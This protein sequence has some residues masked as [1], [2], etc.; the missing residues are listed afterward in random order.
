MLSVQDMV[1]PRECLRRCISLATMCFDDETRKQKLWPLALRYLEEAK[2]KLQHCK[3]AFFE[4]CSDFE[5]KVLTADIPLPLQILEGDLVGGAVVDAK[6]KNSQQSQ[7]QTD[8]TSSS[9]SASAPS[10]P[11]SATSNPLE[12]IHAVT[13][14]TANA[15]NMWKD[16]Y[17]TL[18]ESTSANRSRVDDL[19]QML[20]F[21]QESYEQKTAQQQ[22][23]IEELK[24]QLLQA[25]HMQHIY[26]ESA[27]HLELMH[28]KLRERLKT[29]Q[30]SH[31]KTMAEFVC[32]QE[33]YEK[34]K[35]EHEEEKHEWQFVCQRMQKNT[36]GLQKQVDC[37]QRLFVDTIALLTGEQQAALRNV[38]NQL[39][40]PHNELTLEHA[41][42]RVENP[43]VNS[44]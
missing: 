18:R 40:N 15:R 7:Q 10:A 4:Q 43:H 20:A 27:V 5:R 31:E 9:A 24:R 12:A 23:T 35:R 6:H 3:D 41:V 33:E 1:A 29:V 34:Q 17:F 32:R 38:V 16:K 21:L 2:E 14:A 22:Q 8:S 28:A 11:S 26:E 19:E 36:D 13:I 30:Q 37:Y 25:K 44:A 42:D 39:E